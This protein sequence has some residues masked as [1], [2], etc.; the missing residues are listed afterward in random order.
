MWGVLVY[1]FGVWVRHGEFAGWWDGFMVSLGCV[2]A[3]GVK[4]GG[5]G[6][7]WGL[8]GMIWGLGGV[9]VGHGC[10]VFGT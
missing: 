9:D 4:L 1:D 8:N 2:G 3:W 6:G 10:G 7:V 5:V